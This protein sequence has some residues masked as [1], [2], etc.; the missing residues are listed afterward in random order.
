M[1]ILILVL[2]ALIASM[3]GLG[4]LRPEQTGQ[5]TKIGQTVFMTCVAATILVC[6]GSAAHVAREGWVVHYELGTNNHDVILSPERWGL[7]T[8]LIASFM[9]LPLV[10]LCFGRRIAS[11]R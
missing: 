6:W 7:F 9:W 1:T 11:K 10:A 2:G 3:F 5:G 8:V 4:Y